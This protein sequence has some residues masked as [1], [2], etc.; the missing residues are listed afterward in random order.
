MDIWNSNERIV[1]LFKNFI[2]LYIAASIYNCKPLKSLANDKP[3]SLLE[4]KKFSTSLDYTKVT[5]IGTGLR[6]YYYTTHRP[7]MLFALAASV[8]TYIIVKFKD[9]G[10]SS[11]QSML[12]ASFLVTPLFLIYRYDRPIANFTLHW[13]FSS[14]ILCIYFS[15][16]LFLKYFVYSKVLES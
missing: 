9:W 1:L 3:E 15:F 4:H 10:Y 13:I 6:S 14:F 16:S 11:S 7:S 8:Y 12:R 2:R 5:E